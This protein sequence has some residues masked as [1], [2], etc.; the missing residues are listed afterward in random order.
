MRSAGCY[1]SLRLT[2]YERAETMTEKELELSCTDCASAGCGKPNGNYPEFCPTKAMSEA[3]HESAAQT[4]EDDPFALEVMR[5][6][7]AVSAAGFDRH[8]CRAE[9]TIAFALQ[10]G[11]KRIGIACCAGLMEEGRIFARILRA[12]GLEPFG[13]CCKVGSVPKGRLGAQASCCDV[14]EISCNPLLQA[15]LLA[16]ADTQLNVVLGLCVGHDTLFYQ[17]SEAPVTTLVAKDRATAHNP[18]GALRAATSASFYNTMLKPNDS[19]G[20]KL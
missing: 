7:S 8:W 20:I 3:D 9:E 12:Q 18:A 11:W 19:L 4:Y 5:A 10:M 16:E 15:K 1:D 6:A 13:I 14:G 2:N 17:H